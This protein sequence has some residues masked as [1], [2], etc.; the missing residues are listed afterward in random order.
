MGQHRLRIAI[1]ALVAAILT[2]CAGAPAKKEK[3]DPLMVRDSRECRSLS[4][5]DGMERN[6]PQAYRAQA[7]YSKCMRDRGWPGE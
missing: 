5:M 2:A 7:H 3:K 4:H 6:G 1:L